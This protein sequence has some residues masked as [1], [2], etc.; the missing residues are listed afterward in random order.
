MSSKLYTKEIRKIA[1]DKEKELHPG[2]IATLHKCGNSLNFNPHVHIVATR[3]IINMKTGELKDISF[4]PY[5][6]FR[7]TWMNTFCKH[8]EKENIISKEESA[9]IKTSYGNG[10][11]VYFQPI[12]GNEN[13]VIFRTAEYIASGYFH[14]S[15]IVSVDHE[16]MTVT[17]KYRSWQIEL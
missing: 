14:N 13:D 5:K 16:K 8:L 10:F 1:G 15:Q 3:E 17:F 4:I 6:K 9:S 7:F 12:N 2:M 11:H